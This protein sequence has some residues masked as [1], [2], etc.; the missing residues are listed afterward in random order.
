[1]RRGVT[2]GKG[3]DK[4]LRKFQQVR[5]IQDEMIGLAKEADWWIVEQKLQ[6]D[7]FESVASRL[8]SGEAMEENFHLVEQQLTSQ[9]HLWEAE[10]RTANAAQEAKVVLP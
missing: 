3:E 2:T 8:W 1:V 6:S 5:A 10:R 4:K 9:S 7:P